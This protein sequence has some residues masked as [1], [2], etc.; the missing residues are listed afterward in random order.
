MSF[1]EASDD[2]SLISSDSYMNIN[3]IDYNQN[4]WKLKD[5]SDKAQIFYDLPIWINPCG[6]F[7]RVSYDSEKYRVIFTA[8]FDIP[9][10]IN[11]NINNS[12]PVK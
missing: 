11:L 12:R 7:T 10:S 9:N 2:S 3:S 1:I 5:N 8:S 6:L 4:Y